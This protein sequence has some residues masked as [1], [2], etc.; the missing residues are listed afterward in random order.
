MYNDLCDMTDIT[1]ISRP[2]NYKVLSHIL[3]LL[4]K[5][6]LKFANLIKRDHKRYGNASYNMPLGMAI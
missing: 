2:E 1:K 4:Q 6:R 5:A 3:L